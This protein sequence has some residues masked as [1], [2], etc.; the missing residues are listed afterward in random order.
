MQL[1]NTLDTGDV[2][3]QLVRGHQGL[4][5]RSF[6]A[7]YSTFYGPDLTAAYSEAFRVLKPGGVFAVYEVALTEAYE[8]DAPS[9]V[10]QSRLPAYGIS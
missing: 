6:D 5:G 9:L 8:D 1:R 7:A 2:N 4:D 10:L 3:G